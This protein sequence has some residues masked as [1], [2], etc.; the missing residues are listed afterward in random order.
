VELQIWRHPLLDVIDRSQEPVQ[1]LDP[2]V[3]Q[4]HRFLRHPAQLFPGFSELHN[5][6]G[7]LMELL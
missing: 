7:T 1:V 5:E 6:E 3:R 4:F 2:L